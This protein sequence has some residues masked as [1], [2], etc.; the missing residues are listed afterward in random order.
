VSEEVEARVF[1]SLCISGKP[2]HML[3]VVQGTKL[4]QTCEDLVR[5]D[6][7]DDLVLGPD[8]CPECIKEQRA[9]EWCHMLM[10][11][12]SGCLFMRDTSGYDNCVMNGCRAIRD[13]DQ[14]KDSP[15]DD[16]LRGIASD[17]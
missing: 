4:Y 10:C 1:Y 12:E 5:V 14:I 13:H 16:Q 3:E 8:E 2:F 9:T 6:M 15:Y 7:F 11:D 17:A